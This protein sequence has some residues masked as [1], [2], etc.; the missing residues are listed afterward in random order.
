MSAAKRWLKGGF[1]KFSRLDGFGSSSFECV[2]HFVSLIVDLRISRTLA[3]ADISRRIV[4]SSCIMKGNSSIYASTAQHDDRASRGEK[5]EKYSRTRKYFLWHNW[6]GLD[7]DPTTTTR[8]NIFDKCSHF[9]FSLSL[10]FHLIFFYFNFV[11]FSSISRFFLYDFHLQK[12]ATNKRKSDAHYLLARLRNILM[13]LKLIVMYALSMSDC[14]RNIFFLFFIIIPLP[15]RFSHPFN[16]FL[17]YERISQEGDE[18]FASTSSNL[19]EFMIQY[20][21]MWV[22]VRQ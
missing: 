12:S 15:L 1:E 11:C 13:S 14:I 8:L 2:R 16:Y 20:V 17:N 6:V 4:Q 19:N 7:H 22:D 9:L 21:E 3:L 18:W 10:A 5:E